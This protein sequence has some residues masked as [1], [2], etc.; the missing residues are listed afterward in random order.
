MNCPLEYYP[1][2]HNTSGTIHQL[3]LCKKKELIEVYIDEYPESIFEKDKHGTSLIGNCVSIGNEECLKMLIKRGC[4]MNEKNNKGITPLFVAL[5]KGKKKIIELLEEGMKLNWTSVELIQRD[6][7]GFCIMHYLAQT[8]YLLEWYKKYKLNRFIEDQVNVYKATPLFIAAQYKNSKAINELLTL[9]ASPM[10]PNIYGQIPLMISLEKGDIES[11]RLLFK[12]LTN[13]AYSDK[14]GRQLIHYAIKSHKIEIV[15]ELLK[16]YGYQENSVI[17]LQNCLYEI[18]ESGKFNGF[19]ELMKKELHQMEIDFNKQNLCDNDGFHLIYYTIYYDFPELIQLICIWDKEALK[20]RIY[21]GWTPLLYASS[22]GRKSC[23]LTIIKILGKNCLLDK[24]NEGE[25]ALQLACYYKHY[26]IVSVLL[27]QEIDLIHQVDNYK[28]NIFHYTVSGGERN[29]LRMLYDKIKEK[30]MIKEINSYQ[31][32]VLHI[33][34]LS[35]CSSITL[36]L[37]NKY[38]VNPQQIDQYGNSPF[39]YAVLAN[40]SDTF[41]VNLLKRYYAD[42]PQDHL[43]RTP[44]HIACCCGNSYIIPVLIKKYPSCINTQDSFLKTPLH[45]AVAMNH[46]ECVDILIQNHCNTT[47]IDSKG[48][49][50]IEYAQCSYCICRLLNRDPLCIK[51][52][53]ITERDKESMNIFSVGTIVRVVFQNNNNQ[54]F[55]LYENKLTQIHLI[56]YKKIPLNPTEKQQLLQLSHQFKINLVF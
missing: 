6:V 40:N 12:G 44:L 8:N 52:Y 28:N 54:M 32:N 25:N 7:K 10:K 24:G 46:P 3:L 47:I 51:K 2:E 49:R 1:K 9:G 30:S 19:N 20:R 36:E 31:Q 55:I 27:E 48:K 43:K 14:K 15:G 56:S 13:N 53:I 33:G 11:I 22:F 26:D 18:Q 50:A 5:H 45:Y 17:C 38:S 35:G 16:L 34:S 23:L 41:L 29:I 21:N 42:I 4:K 39:H 37:I